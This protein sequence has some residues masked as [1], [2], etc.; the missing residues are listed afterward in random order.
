MRTL[1]LVI[2]QIEYTEVDNGLFKQTAYTE[3]EATLYDYE[4]ID[5]I[6]SNTINGSLVENYYIPSTNT[7][8]IKLEKFNRA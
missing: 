7:F 5:L 8:V 2:R 3:R 6:T 1:N 4:Y